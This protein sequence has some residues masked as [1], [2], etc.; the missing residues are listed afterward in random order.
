MT[1][2][3]RII[4]TGAAGLVGQSFVAKLKGRKGLEGINIDKHLAQP[5]GWEH[6]F[7]RGGTLILKRAR[8]GELTEQPLI[9]T[10]I[11]VKYACIFT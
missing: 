8:T 9:D 1:A 7:D 5:G 6:A 4:I 11:S 3:K 2:S 10:N